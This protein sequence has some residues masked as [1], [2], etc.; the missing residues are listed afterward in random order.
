MTANDLRRIELEIEYGPV[1]QS[2]NNVLNSEDLEDVE[3]AEDVELENS[4]KSQ[5]NNYTIAHDEQ[6]DIN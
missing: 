5:E 2:C 3:D 4:E 6:Q 1:V